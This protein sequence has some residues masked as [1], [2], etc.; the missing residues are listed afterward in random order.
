[1]LGHVQ[2]SD[3]SPAV[4]SG[5]LCFRVFCSNV[6]YTTLRYVGTSHGPYVRTG[7]FGRWRSRRRTCSFAR[8]I[9]PQQHCLISR[10]KGYL[11][12]KICLIIKKY[13]TFQYELY[14]YLSPL[15]LLLIFYALFIAITSLISVSNTQ[16]TL[17][18]ETEGVLVKEETTSV[19]AA[20]S[21]KKVTE[22]CCAVSLK[23]RRAA[24][25][26]GVQP[27]QKGSVTKG[28][29]ANPM[30]RNISAQPKHKQE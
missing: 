27:S 17:L 4:V 29:L 22:F 11:A 28:D 16:T 2:V 7:A 10:I 3:C 6:Q 14:F 21:R 25:T 26:V 30:K 18:S 24:A 15:L 8:A 23:F 1:M 13:L 19:W 5:R 12:F 9:L 20:K